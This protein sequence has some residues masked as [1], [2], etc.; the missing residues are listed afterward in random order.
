M[1]L[2]MAV[3]LSSVPGRSLRLSPPCEQL[4]GLTPG[5]SSLH[6]AEHLFGKYDIAMPGDVAQYAGGTEVTKAFRWAAGM[7][8]SGPTIVVETTLGSRT[9][10]AIMVNN[11]PGV[12]TSRNLMAFTPENRA[13]ELY[14]QP[15]YAFQFRMPDGG[16]YREILY[17][18]K[19][20][21]LVLNQ[22]AGRPNWQVTKLIL[23]FPQYLNNAVALRM[24]DAR[25]GGSVEDIT[26]AYRV[27][28]RLAL[29]PE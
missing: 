2:G 10:A 11:Y 19:G 1:A 7:T 6:D 29:P 4:G 25:L 8:L 26:Y 20:I 15:D 12:A 14:G 13:I 28:T 16:S 3:M 18:D 22:V 17:L 21:L 27:W 23:T 24:R 5:V 9:I